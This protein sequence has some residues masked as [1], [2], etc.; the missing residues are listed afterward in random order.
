MEMDFVI[1][2]LVM[3]FVLFLYIHITS[4]YKKSED[5]EIYEMDYTT[6]KELQEV[7][8]LKQPFLFYYKK[9]NPRFFDKLTDEKLTEIAS[10]GSLKVK[11]AGDY[12]AEMPEDKT[13][14]DY[15]L[16]PLS[17][18]QMLYSTDTRSRY[19]T[20]DNHEFLEEINMLNLF[21]DNDDLLKPTMTIHRKYDVMM[22]SKNVTTP[23]RYHTDYR[24]FICV[25]SGKITVKMTPFRS[26]K[27]LHGK[28]DFYNYEFWSPVNVWSPQEKYMNDMEKAKFIEFDVLS[29]TTLYIPPYWWY[30]VKYREQDTLLSGF[31]YISIM[32]CLANSVDW[33]RY[34]T[35]Q[36]KTN[37]KTKT[38]QID[39]QEKI[40]SIE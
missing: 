29:G 18:F 17:S 34:F 10:T 9:W 5:L 39:N 20:E 35:E 21:S 30:S 8:D 23:I 2:I 38:I 13:S 1:N 15:V 24:R 26:N 40:D 25:H 6:N 28:K 12:W 14:I 36:S 11:E 3:L 31:T 7:C 4:Q 22:G 27:Y 37:E 16:L 33:F 32:N 19:F